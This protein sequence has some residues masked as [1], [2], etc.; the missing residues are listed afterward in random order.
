MIERFPGLSAAS[1][2]VA[3]VFVHGFTGDRKAT[4]GKIPEFL[5]SDPHL[6]DWDLFGFGYQ[7]RFR[8]DILNLW[9]ADAKLEEIATALFSVPELTPYK[10]LALV[11]HSMGGLVVQR[12]LIKYPELRARTS[13]L[14]LF[15]TPS[16]GL[17][18]ASVVSFL[19]QQLNNMSTSGQFIKQLRSDWTDLKLNVT[20]PFDFLAVAG[21]LDQFVPPASSLEPF[22]ESVRRV[23]PGNHVTMLRA[24]ESGAAPVRLLS[25]FLSRGATPGGV[26]TAARLAVEKGEFQEVVDRLWPLR[27]EID[28]AGAVTLALALDALG[29]RQDSIAVLESHQ[30][31][32]TDPLGT[33][34]G[35]YKRRWLVE[36]RQSDLDRAFELYRA[37]YL[38]VTTSDPVN[39]SQAYYLG[40]NLMYLE[41]AANGNYDAARNL[42]AA[43][44]QHCRLDANPTGVFWR[45]AT[46][47]D[48]LITL[49]LKQDAL[50][51]HA[52]AAGQQMNPW[53]A[54]SIQEQSLDVAGLCGWDR[55]ELERLSGLYQGRV[56]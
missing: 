45:L 29:R 15:G 35:R 34:A 9:S 21:E 36:R 30:A 17:S 41:M 23:I 49:G 31:K 1:N 18:K 52:Q 14:L 20:R 33:L 6:R 48:A 13:H 4:W 25:D 56:Q 44:R 46:E 5:A 24:D 54:L 12:A 26:R 53:Q 38:R 27:S 8:F 3:L 51:A 55:T 28:D 40:T 50:A 22:P 43:V 2:Q 32:G 42:A 7:S 37:G 10:R 19:K 47:G 39:H 11:A 16:N